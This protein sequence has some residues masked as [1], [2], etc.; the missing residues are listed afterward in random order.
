MRML[1]TA[2]SQRG[3]LLLAK[4]AS[5]AMSSNPQMH[6][7][8]PSSSART[9]H[10][11]DDGDG[12]PGFSND[13]APKDTK[14]DPDARTNRRCNR[15]YPEPPRARVTPLDHSIA[16]HL[17]KCLPYQGNVTSS[18]QRSRKPSTSYCVA[19]LSGVWSSRRSKK[20]D[21]GQC[22]PQPVKSR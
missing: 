11:G 22:H 15:L 4:R 13:F 1:R 19:L 7:L 8:E 3:V 16:R 17:C 5:S 21:L 12:S 14:P 6:R 20:R 9:F 2:M 18:S 10:Q